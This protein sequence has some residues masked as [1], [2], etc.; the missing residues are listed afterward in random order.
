MTPRAGRRIRIIESSAKL[1]AP[2]GTSLQASG[3]DMSSP[4]QVN[5]RGMTP[6]SGKALEVSRIAASFARAVGHRP[7][8][9]LRRITKCSAWD[10]GIAPVHANAGPIPL[11]D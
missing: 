9:G 10:D 1:R 7:R 5:R 11:L 3:G 6:P 8:E 2:G 4:S